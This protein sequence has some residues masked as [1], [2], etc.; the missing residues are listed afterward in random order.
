MRLA[1]DPRRD[2]VRRGASSAELAVLLPVLMLIVLGCIDFGRFGYN[3]IAVTNAARTGA[4]YAVMTP[5]LTSGQSAWQTKI[6]EK[7]RDEMYQQTGYNA[8]NLTTAAAVT[9]EGNGL[10]RVRV[11]ATYSSFQT[12]IPWPG[13]PSQ[14]TLRSAVE[15]RVIR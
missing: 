10:R 11:T 9:I 5:Y 15:T 3:Y 14:V 7:A 8:N 6:Q 1:K 13:I 2:G 12:L 4:E